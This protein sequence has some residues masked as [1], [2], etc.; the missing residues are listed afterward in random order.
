[1]EARGAVYPDSDIE[2]VLAAALSLP[3]ANALRRWTYHCLFGLIALAGL[4]H[5]EALHLC[6]D[7][8]DLD[9]GI[10]T[11]YEAKVG[12]WWQ[13]PPRATT[14]TVLSDYAA[15]SYAHLGMPRSPMSNGPLVA[16]DCQHG[17]GDAV[18]EVMVLSEVACLTMM[19]GSGASTFATTFE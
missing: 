14:V 18:A 17:F 10:L 7:D 3:P 5:S 8:L 12:K 9:Q 19:F 13:V 11:I 4:R 15:R 16:C 2:A 6:R 1:M